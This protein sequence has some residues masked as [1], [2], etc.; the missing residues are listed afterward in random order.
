MQYMDKNKFFGKKIAVLGLSTEGLASV[1]YLL[2]KGASLTIYDQKTE[3][4]YSSDLLNFLKIKKINLILGNKYLQSLT[5]NDL[6]VRTPGFPLWNREIQKACDAGVEIT[7]Q[8]KIFFD[9]CPGKIIGV[10]GTKGKGTTA[11]LIYKLIRISNKDVFLGGNIGTPPLS[12]LEKVKKT[13]WVVLELSSFQLADLDKSPHVAVILNITSD[14]LYSAS[15][16]SPNYHLSH[17]EYLRAKKNIVCHQKQSDYVIINR[18]YDSSCSF[19]E[20]TP[21]KKWLFSK[22]KVVSFGS[23][24]K[25]K[26]IYLAYGTRPY[27]ICNI[28]AVK[29]RG[30]HN[31]ENITAAITAAHLAGVKIHKMKKALS[32]FKGLEHRLELVRI[33]QG[34]KFYN[35]SFSTTPETTIAALRSFGE[36]IIL[37]CGGSEKG[38]DYSQLGME[39]LMGNVKKIILIGQTA[40][41]IKQLIYKAAKSRK[42][43]IPKIIDGFKTMTEIVKQAYSAASAGDVVL[44]S[45]ACASFDMFK[46]YKER[47]LLFKQAVKN[48]K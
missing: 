29:L 42:R 24:V 41:K 22:E 45:P 44:L 1:K 31:L 19:R 4:D 32:T 13:S 23:F 21:A 11:T 17:E 25:N 6:I 16:D 2:T 28:S 12:F 26:K 27:F 36:P 37:I 7:S 38:S 39:I 10:T 46:N 35:D 20:Y 47:G 33:H 15:V 43:S 34:I 18:D 9:L 14:H 3:K 8:T 5:N 48:L 30:V 40:P